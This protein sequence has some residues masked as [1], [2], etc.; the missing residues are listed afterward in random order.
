MRNRGRT[1]IIGQIMEVAENGCNKT[2]I[3]YK[4]YLSFDQL[5]QYLTL[6]TENGLLEYS[7]EKKEYRTTEKGKEF[8][9]IYRQVIHIALHSKPALDPN[10]YF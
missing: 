7:A 3:M 6:V 10:V 1:D 9:R 2:T 4:A 8:L 5:N